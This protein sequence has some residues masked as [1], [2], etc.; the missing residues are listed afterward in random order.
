MTLQR[1]MQAQ[2]INFSILIE[3][4]FLL[5]ESEICQNQMR[6][7]KNYIFIHPVVASCHVQMPL[8]SVHIFVQE[9]QYLES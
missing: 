4:K 6:L 2:H 9:V 1:L 5:L 7:R 8:R 3:I